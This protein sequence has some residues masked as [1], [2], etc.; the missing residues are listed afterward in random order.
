MV[1]VYND[2]LNLIQ[3]HS[4]LVH[5]SNR[6][7]PNDDRNVSL[8]DPIGICKPSSSSMGGISPGL[9]SF[10]AAAVGVGV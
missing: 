6:L 7:C 10:R 1:T 9:D 8:K 2:N 5:A 4:L 3:L